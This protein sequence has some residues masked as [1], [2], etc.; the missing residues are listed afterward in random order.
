M[1]F[2]STHLSKDEKEY[3]RSVIW[4]LGVLL[5]K[6]DDG[7]FLLCY[8]NFKSAK[9]IKVESVKVT[10][11]HCRVILLYNVKFCHSTIL[12]KCR[13]RQGDQI[14]NSGNRKGRVRE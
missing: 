9:V 6:D 12:I 11:T 13:Y 5:R 1:H 4:K 2:R 3:R 8:I 10:H 7:F 14:E